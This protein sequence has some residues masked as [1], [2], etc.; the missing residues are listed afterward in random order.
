MSTMPAWSYSSLTAYETC[1]KR[2]Y[3]TKVTKEIIEPQTE[4]T[5]WGNKV[6]KALELRIKDKTPLPVTMQAYEPYCS[7]I[8]IT[9]AQ[10][11]AE[12]KMALNAQFQPTKW[13]AK[14]CWVR[15]ILDVQIDAGE[16]AAVLDWKT[17]AV[18]PDSTQL[19]LSAAFMFHSKPYVQTVT[20]SF[21]WLKENTA[22]R[23][24]FEREQLPEIWNEFLPRVKRLEL[25]YEK[26][27]WEAKPSGLCKDWCPVGK[28]KCEHCG[29]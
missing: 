24:T 25:A 27:R 7:R 29:S 6:H 15:S 20:T 2:Y 11:S 9:P 22:T 26:D 1:P 14:D 21:I 28:A 12:T 13:M 18:K 5:L 10:I 3:L 23:E 17:G 19:M 8:E 16:K 4:A